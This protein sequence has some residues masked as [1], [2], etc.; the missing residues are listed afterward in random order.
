V[1]DA[2]SL[3]DQLVSS[4]EVITLALAQQVLGTAPHQMVLDVVEAIQQRQSAE[5]L[6]RIHQAL[7]SGSDPR[8]FARQVVDYLRNL[9][10]VRLGNADQVDA[11]PEL[12]AQMARHAQGFDLPELLRLIRVFNQAANEARNAWQPSLPLEMALVEALAGDTQEKDASGGAT[13]AVTPPPRAGQTRAGAAPAPAEKPLVE[14]Q[15]S[16]PWSEDEQLLKLVREHWRQILSVIRSQD[17]KTEALLKSGKLLGVK[18]GTLYFGFSEALKS[19]MEKDEN[20][21]LVQKALHQ[22][23]KQEVPLRC[24]V[25]TGKGGALPPDLDSDGMVATALR[26]LGGEIVDVQ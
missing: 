16:V 2:I 9:L 5:G 7:D 19:K 23:L 13:P 11:T 18:N 14:D 17:M 24:V 25:Y 12:R 8:Q 15:A 3:L 22:V 26:D 10:L 6:E 20:L 1:R 4:A 21:T